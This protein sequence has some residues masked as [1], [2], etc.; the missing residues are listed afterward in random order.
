L[1]KKGDIFE[2]KLL[3]SKIL[4]N[5]QEMRTDL[6]MKNVNVDG[7]NEDENESF[8]ADEKDFEAI[9]F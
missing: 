5:I 1:R 9:K 6:R 4:V 7:K 2:Y 8:E 3:S